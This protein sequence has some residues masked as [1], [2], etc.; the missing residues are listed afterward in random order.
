MTCCASFASSRM[1]TCWS[2]SGRPVALVKFD[3]VRPSSRARSFIM[4]ANVAS[5][6]AM[7]S[8]IAMQASL[9]DCTITPC[10]RSITFTRLF[11]G[12]NMV[13]P[14]DGAPPRRQAFSLMMNSVLRSRSPSLIWWRTSS[15]V[16]SLARLAGEVSWSAAFS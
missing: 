5:L 16:I 9:P 3:L 14:P 12:A 8:A 6:P 2:G 1:V 13:E 7:P 15:T 11:S 4:R 10:R